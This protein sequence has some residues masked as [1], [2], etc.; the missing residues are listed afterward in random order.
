MRAPLSAY[1]RAR[2]MSV[3]LAPVRNACNASPTRDALPG[4]RANGE[5]E[6]RAGEKSGL[7]ARVR[8]CDL[9]TG[10]LLFLFSPFFFGSLRRTFVH[11]ARAHAQV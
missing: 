1:P 7:S 5:K 4:P 3:I 9:I 10:L 2:V 6:A 11:D 8:A